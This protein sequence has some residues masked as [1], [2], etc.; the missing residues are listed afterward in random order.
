MRR[1]IRPIV[2]TLFLVAA[3]TSLSGCGPL[4]VAYVMG[5]TVAQEKNR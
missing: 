5:R 1:I 2:T 3:L 4:M